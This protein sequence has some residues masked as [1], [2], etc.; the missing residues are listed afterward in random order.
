MKWT[1]LSKYGIL[2]KKD[3]FGIVSPGIRQANAMRIIHKIAR[4]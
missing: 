1:I 3:V 2:E 4:Q